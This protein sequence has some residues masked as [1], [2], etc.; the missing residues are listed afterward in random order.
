MKEKRKEGNGPRAS[1]HFEGKG[2]NPRCAVLAFRRVRAGEKSVQEKKRGRGAFISQSRGF[3][4]EEE[5]VVFHIV[6]KKKI[7]KKGKA[8][9]S[10]IREK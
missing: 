1:L 4:Q 6:L 9:P 5:S 2:G 7:E 10:T 3:R 8:V